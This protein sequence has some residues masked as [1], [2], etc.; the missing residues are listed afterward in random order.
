MKPARGA[1]GV[2]HDFYFYNSAGSV[3]NGTVFVAWADGDY[4]AYRV[5]ATELGTSG[6]YPVPTPP[7]NATNYELRVRGAS[8]AASYV[9][10]EGDTPLGVKSDIR[11]GLAGRW[12]NGGTGVNFDDI[13]IVD[14]P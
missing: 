2:N 10:Y 7:A 4:A 8:L 14:T 12:T 9:V 5:A 3:W 1:S 6:R 13:T 11:S